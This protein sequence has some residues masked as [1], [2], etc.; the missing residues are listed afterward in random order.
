MLFE[1]KQ[2]IAAHGLDHLER[3]VADLL[4]TGA[5]DT[6]HGHQAG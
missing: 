5:Y 4:D 1:A 3:D 2:L 6:A